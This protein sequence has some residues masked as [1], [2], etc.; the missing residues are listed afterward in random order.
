MEARWRKDG[1]L[2]P[3][4]GGNGRKSIRYPAA[5]CE[6]CRAAVVDS[7]GLPVQ[8]FNEDFSGCGLRIVTR[9]RTYVGSDAENLAL[10]VNNIEC[11]A[12]EH[13]FGGVVVQPV[14]AWNAEQ[15]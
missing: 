1:G 15:D 4:C 2:C 12:Q 11:R 6:L 7:A 3:T 8:L 13:R 10:Y 5:L 9:V 14:D